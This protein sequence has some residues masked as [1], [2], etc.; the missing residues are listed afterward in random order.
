[1]SYRDTRKSLALLVAVAVLLGTAIGGGA[2]SDQTRQTKPATTTQAEP[3]DDD[4]FAAQV[5]PVV[6]RVCVMCHTVENFTKRRRTAKEWNDVVVAMTG[7]G[8]VATPDEF[9]LIKRYMTRFYGVVRINTATAEEIAAVLGVSPKV[10]DAVVEYRKT[11]GR[12]TDL[13]SLLKVEGLDR[14]KLEDD[15]EAILYN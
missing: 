10:A 9:L 8:A 1:M 12:F 4:A 5:E 7:R 14:T 13:E 6:E 3:L 11:H 15:P 2:S